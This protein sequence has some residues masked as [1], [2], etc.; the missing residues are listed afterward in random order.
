[1]NIDAITAIKNQIDTAT[2]FAAVFGPTSGSAAERK[3]AVRKAFVFLAKSVHPD[4][5]AGNEKLAQNAFE[6]LNATRQRA[7]DAIENGTYDTTFEPGLK[8]AATRVIVSKMRSWT[9]F[10]TPLAQGDTSV[11]YKG[12]ATDDKTVTIAAK[13]ALNPTLNATLQAEANLAQKWMS[14]ATNDPLYKIKCFMPDVLDQFTVADAGRQHRVTIMRRMPE[15]VSLTSILEAFKGKNISAGLPPQAAA[16]IGRRV[17]AQTLAARLVGMVHTAIVPDHVLVGPFNHEPLH[18]GWA[19]ALPLSTSKKP[20]MTAVIDRWRSC[21]PP[22]VFAKT[23]VGHTSDIYM[24]GMCLLALF[25]GQPGA[26][27]KTVTATKDIDEIIQACIASKP[28]KRP[29]DGVVVLNEFTDAVRKT[30]GNKYVPLVLA[31]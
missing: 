19:H 7:E 13:V 17:I 26:T 11:V 12:Y 20:V 23:P 16:W 6:A 4:H 28:E 3:R 18:I 27:S 25:G 14:A 1:M 24:A 8:P 5:N 15:M 29:A 31:N 9:I 10:D 2:T 30:W 22:E 21:Y